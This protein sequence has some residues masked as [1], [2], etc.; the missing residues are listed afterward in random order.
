[1]SVTPLPGVPGAKGRHRILCG[2]S[3]L[4]VLGGHPYLS[5]LVH[6]N[7]GHVEI[8]VSVALSPKEARFLAEMLFAQAAE[9]ERVT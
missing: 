7:G 8:T 9:T 1:M 5:L 3:D 2:P 4:Q 6:S